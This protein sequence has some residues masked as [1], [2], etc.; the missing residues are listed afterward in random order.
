MEPPFDMS[1]FSEA[2]ID[3]LRAKFDNRMAELATMQKDMQALSASATSPQRLLTVTVGAQGE[4]TG[5][6]FHS[7]GYRSMAQPELE[8]VILKTTQ[9]ARGKVMSK[10][11][12]LMAP[13]APAGVDID[14]LMEG[15][16]A[17]G[18]LMANHD[19]SPKGAQASAAYQEDG[20]ED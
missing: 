3:E 14:D 13:L 10:L 15:R 4:V 5:V 6:K 11:K 19:L 20:D 16:V 7:D 17:P 2:S 18:D 1:G 12:G 9:V 8:H